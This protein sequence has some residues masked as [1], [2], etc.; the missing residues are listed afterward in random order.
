MSALHKKFMGIP[1]PTDVLTFP[2]ETDAHGCVITGEV[3]VCVSQALRQ[4]RAR[5]IPPRL[6]L[7]LYALHGLLHLLG[8]DDRTDSA[9]RIMHRTE[10]AILT[11][12]GFGPVFAATT[13]PPP[14]GGRS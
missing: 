4:A 13:A 6:E 12:L 11:E 14:R 3:I 7:L 9:F 1:G 5:T 10:D 8:Y 2:M